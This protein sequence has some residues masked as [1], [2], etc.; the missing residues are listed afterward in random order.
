MSDREL[1]E[2]AAKAAGIDLSTRKWHGRWYVSPEPNTKNWNPLEDDGDALRLAV[3]VSVST[4]SGLKIMMP[5]SKDPW[6]V[7][8][9]YDYTDAEGR[10]AEPNP[11][12]ATRR[13]IVLAA[14]ELGKAKP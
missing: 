8:N 14:A 3:A 13:A 11:Y 7:V 12:A 5:D 9:D 2:L 10:C 1:L 6:A 4:N